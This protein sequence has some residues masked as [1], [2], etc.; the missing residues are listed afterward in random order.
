MLIH[1][2]AA[3]VCQ[4]FMSIFYMA[5][6]DFEFQEIHNIIALIKGWIEFSALYFYQ[7]I[8]YTTDPC[9][10]NQRFDNFVLHMHLQLMPIKE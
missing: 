9:M 10:H 5:N 6:W 2:S 3:Q 7:T 8:S 4:V 1:T